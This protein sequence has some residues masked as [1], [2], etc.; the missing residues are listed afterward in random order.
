[1]TTAVDY[2]DALGQLADGS[3]AAPAYYIISGSQS[4]QAAVL[5]RNRN[6]LENL[7]PLDIKHSWYLLETNYV[8]ERIIDLVMRNGLVISI[9]SLETG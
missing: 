6:D 3:I 9:G 1:M 5:T 4:N 7:W 8:C 2:E